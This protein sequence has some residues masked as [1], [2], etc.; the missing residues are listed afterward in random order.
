[1]KKWLC[2]LLLLLI[3]S[4]A[5]A[6]TE[7]L[8]FYENFCESCRPMEEFAEEYERLTGQPLSE[9]HCEGFNVLHSS[10]RARYEAF[11]EEAGLSEDQRAIP[12]VV[13]DGTVYAGREAVSFDLPRDCL[14]EPG[15]ADSAVLLVSCGEC[16]D[17]AAVEAWL[18]ALPESW[19]LSRGDYAF[20]SALTLEIASFAEAKER[21]LLPADAEE[22]APV[23]LLGRRQYTGADAIYKDVER[24][25]RSGAA[26]GGV[27]PEK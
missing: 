7:V 14:S 6:E 2:A 24:A 10:G 20:D 21:G 23:V 5:L 27:Q 17:C 18:R 9:T 22:T 15:A 3:S 12:T 8:Y 11:C 1:M 16:A 13:R 25:L 4:G 19:A 26:V